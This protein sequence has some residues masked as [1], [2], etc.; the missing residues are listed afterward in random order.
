MD[1][2]GDILLIAVLYT[3]LGLFDDFFSMVVQTKMK[4]MISSCQPRRVVQFLNK[5]IYVI[6]DIVHIL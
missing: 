3:L 6:T 1:S 2:L 5:Q 4:F